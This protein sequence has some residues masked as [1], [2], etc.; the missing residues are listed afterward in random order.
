VTKTNI[1]STQQHE[2]NHYSSEEEQLIRLLKQ[3]P[4]ILQRHP[5][6]M[7]ELEIP[8]DT[9][10]ASSLIERQVFMLRDRI[11]A[12]D[13]RL[14]NLMDIAR[15]NE[16]LAHSHHR[17]AVNLLGAHDLNDVISCVVA[18]LGT[19]LKADFVV[20]RLFSNDESQLAQ[21]P[22]LFVRSNAEPLTAF[23]TM[24]KH[25]NPVCG[26][27]SREQIAFLFGDDAEQVE[28][29]AVIPLVAGADLGLLGLGGRESSRFTSNMG[30]EF[31][32]QIGEMV[33]VALAV[34]LEQS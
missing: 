4:D 6:L 25:R 24:L 5:Q 21:N 12:H 7:L 32:N 31:L 10:G 28:S 23:A 11:K 2:Q 26:R 34:H 27:S 1:Q 22:D 16:R 20:M 9:E 8:H 18:E 14:R 17:I 3:H 13:K 15:A 29:A 30:T 19:E 33:S